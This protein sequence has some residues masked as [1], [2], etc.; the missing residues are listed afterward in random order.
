[1]NPRRIKPIAVK[2]FRQIVRDRRSLILLLI[3]PALLMVLFGYALNFDVKHVSLAVLDQDNSRA[4]REFIQSLVHSEYFDLRGY[5]SRLQEVDEL[6]DESRVQAV[7]VVP[8]DFGVQLAA[9]REVKVQVNLDGANSNSASAVLGYMTA[10]CQSYSARIL[11]DALLRSGRGDLALPIDYRPR[12]WYNP[13][14]RS[15]RFLIPGL[16]AIILLIMTVVSTSLSIV[17][18]KERGTME[19]IIVSPVQPIEIILGKTIPYVLISLAASVVIL[20]TGWGLFGIAVRGSMLLLYLGMFVF[21]LGGLGLG[22]LISTLTHSQQ[23]AFMISALLTMLPTIILSGFIFPI[24]NMPFVIR[25]V[26]YVIPARYFLPI[27]RGIIVK[28]VGLGALWSEYLFLL[29]FAVLVILLSTARLRRQM[30]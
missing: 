28:G 22:L 26:S 12:V 30:A 17:R 15:A 8:S 24:R 16:I 5:L 3:Y 27:L 25:L 2:E 1:V 20:L 23:A 13:E 18:E 10:A 21:L 7:L 6:L 29:G 19:Q 11:T 4:S 9:G 14:L